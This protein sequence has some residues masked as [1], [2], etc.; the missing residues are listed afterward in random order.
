LRPRMRRMKHLL[1]SLEGRIAALPVALAVELPGGERVGAAV[2]DVLLRFQDR[3]ALVA[4]AAGEI[5]DVGV[6][7]VEGRVDLRGSMRD[8]MAAAAGLLIRDPARDQHDGWW[9]RV[10]A[11]ARSMAMHTLSHDARHVQF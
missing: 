9:Q 10:R 7:I 1:H 5:G 6:A 8:L 3:M 2:P 4:L 11:R